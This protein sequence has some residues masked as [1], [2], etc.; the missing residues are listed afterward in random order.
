MSTPSSR[1]SSA[2]SSIIARGRSPSESGSRPGPQNLPVAFPGPPLPRG[3]FVGPGVP[4]EDLCR[5]C[6][7]DINFPCAIYQIRACP[8][9]I[10]GLRQCHVCHNGSGLHPMVLENGNRA[11]CNACVGTGRMIPCLLCRGSLQVPCHECGRRNRLCDTCRGLGLVECHKCQAQGRH[12]CEQCNAECWIVVFDHFCAGDPPGGPAV[13]RRHPN[14]QYYPRVDWGRVEV[15][16][17]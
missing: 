2:S 1:S 3:P 14:S 6:H 15:W 4:D 10:N 8:H 17:D 5:S 16:E 11:D 13:R 9:C 7:G 12:R